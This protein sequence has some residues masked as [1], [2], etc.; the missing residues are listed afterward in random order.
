MKRRMRKHHELGTSYGNGVVGPSRK[1]VRAAIETLPENLGWTELAESLRPVFVRRRPLPPGIERPVTTLRPPGLEVALGVDIGPA[2]MYV[3]HGMLETWGVTEADA[4]E[5]AMANLRSS[6][7]AE[8]YVEMEYESIDGVPFWW[9]QSQGGLASGLLLL[10]DELATRY[11]PDPRLLIAPMRNLLLAAPF[12]A[13][14]SLV[15]WLRDEISYD[16]PNGLD[17]PIFALI[18]GRLSIDTR[19]ERLQ[20]AVV[21]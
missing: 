15:S 13:D 21:H 7:A 14:R 3:G 19:V 12:D 2:F 16:D 5:R 11:G 1:Q 8:K 17:L 18:D 4:F 10:E 20:A 6:V 9:Y